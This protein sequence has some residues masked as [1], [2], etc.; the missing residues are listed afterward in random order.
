MFRA[1]LVVAI[2][3]GRGVTEDGGQT[4]PIE[5]GARIGGTMTTILTMVAGEVGVLNETETETEPASGTGI[6]TGGN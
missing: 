4:E 5:D 3:L 2:A 1:M 6:Y